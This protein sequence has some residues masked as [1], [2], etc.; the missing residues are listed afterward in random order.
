MA[1]SVSL[2]R[3]HRDRRQAQRSHRTPEFDQHLSIFLRF[4]VPTPAQ[5][6][7]LNRVFEGVEGIDILQVAALALAL[8]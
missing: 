7:S 3:N 2:R 8:F 4:S 1:S 6:S 5:V